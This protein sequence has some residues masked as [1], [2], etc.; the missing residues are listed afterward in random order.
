M[1]FERSR[2]M[3]WVDEEPALLVSYQVLSAAEGRGIVD[4]RMMETADWVAIYQAD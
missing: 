3:R 1:P 2:V 4:E